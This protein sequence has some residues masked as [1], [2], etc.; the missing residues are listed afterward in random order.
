MD[1]RHPTIWI[2]YSPQFENAAVDL[3]EKYRRLGAQATVLR[4]DSYDRLRYFKGLLCYFH[5]DQVA[6]KIA[7]VLAKDV[8]RIQKV[9]PRLVPLLGIHADF[10]IY[11]VAEAATKQRERDGDLVLCDKCGACVRKDKMARHQ[12]RVHQSSLHEVKPAKRRKQRTILPPPKPRRLV[13]VGAVPKNSPP[14]GAPGKLGW[15]SSY[16]VKSL[17]PRHTRL[18]RLCGKALT[19]YNSRECYACNPK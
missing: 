5:Q 2:T 10:A 19:M 16:T 17:K 1:P 7:R 4:E 9:S 15:S 13:F 6:N 18:C 11:L 12:R 8:S 14:A 3:A